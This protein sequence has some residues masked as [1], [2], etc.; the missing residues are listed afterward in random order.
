MKEYLFSGTSCVNYSQSLLY[1]SSTQK[2][3]QLSVY[4]AMQ[5]AQR[6]WRNANGKP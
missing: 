3:N 5:M 4:G 1:C 2:R 6:K